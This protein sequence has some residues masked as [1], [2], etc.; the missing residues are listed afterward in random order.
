M[1]GFKAGTH[2]YP[3]DGAVNDVGVEDT[4]F[5]Y[6]DAT[7]SQVFIGCDPDPAKADAV[8]D[9]TR[10]YNEALRP[11]AAGAGYVNF[12]MDDEGEGRVKATYGSN[13]PRLQQ[14]KAEYDP[15]NVFRVNQNITP[16]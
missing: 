11:Y 10:G 14:V 12:M 8:R 9:W 3:V 15:E 7:W 1:P 2:F 4:A 5:G 6:R 16:A 13:Y